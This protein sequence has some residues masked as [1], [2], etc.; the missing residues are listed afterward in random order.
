MSISKD[1]HRSQRIARADHLTGQL[2]VVFVDALA[3]PSAAE[4]GEQVLPNLTRQTG[5]RPRQSVHQRAARRRP[6]RPALIALRRHG[7]QQMQPVFALEQMAR[8]AP[9]EEI[10]VLA[11]EVEDFGSPRIQGKFQ[12]DRVGVAPD[13]DLAAIPGGRLVP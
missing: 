13:V 8:V 9:P 5:I 10:L 7:R 2:P 3:N 12:P 11:E 4:V 1:V 6:V